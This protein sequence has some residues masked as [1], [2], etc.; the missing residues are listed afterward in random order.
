VF[1]PTQIDKVLNLV[2][3]CLGRGDEAM[4]NDF[5]WPRA[6]AA[7][8]LVLATLAVSACG[9]RLTADQRV[10]QARTQLAEGDLATAMIHLRNALQEDPMNQGARLLLAEV[11]LQAGDYGSAAKEYR[12]ALDLGAELEPIR[13][14]YA[15][16]LVRS[17]GAEAALAIT[18]PEQAGEGIE[19]QYWRALALMRLGRHEE[20]EPLL[21]R[22][23]ENPSMHARGQVALAR[24]VLSQERPLEALS[25]LEPV[26]EAA[27]G[28]SDYWEVKAFASLQTGQ[29]D[30][31][32]E[33][34]EQ[35]ARTVT[36]ALGNQRF[37]FRGGRVEALLA[38]GKLAEARELAERLRQAADRNPMANYLMARIELQSGNPE[39]AL[40][41][42]QAVL[43][44]DPDSSA[45][46]MVVGAAYQALRQATLAER[47]LARA[48]ALDPGN[49]SAR[50]M[51]AQTRLGLAEPE[52]ALEALGPMA[53]QPGDPQAVALAGLASARAGDLGAAIDLFKRQLEANPQDDETRTLLA[54]SLISAGRV[55][56]AMAELG[57][58]KTTD[59]GARQR[60]ELIAVAAHLQAG[61][62]GKARA[63][64]G[65]LA[66]ASPEDATLRS[67]LGALFLSRNLQDEA[68][69]WFE[70]ALRVDADHVASHYNLGIIAAPAGRLEEARGHFLA[71]LASNP[72]NGAALAA[73]AQIEWFTGRREDAV[74][75]LQ[76]ARAADARDVSARILLA[77]YLVGLN[78][79]AD[80]LVVAREA[81]AAMPDSA[82]AHNTLGSV[83]LVAGHAREALVSFNRAHQLEPGSAGYLVNKARAEASLGQNQEARQ[84]LVNA[85]ALEPENATALVALVD[86]ERRLGRGEAAMQAFRRLERAVPGG[87]PRIELTRGQLLLD[88][89]DA[90]A[91][92]QAYQ[93]ALDGG[94]G[95]QAVI[96]I[97]QARLRGSPG[98]PAEPL[99]TWLR[100]QP[101]DTTVRR[102]LADHYLRSE[103]YAAALLE[104]ELI[105]GT[106][107]DNPAV[108]NNLAWLYQ[109]LDDGRALETAQ[110]AYR[111]APNDPNVA[112]TLGWI[113]YNQGDTARA[114]ELIS[115]AAAAAPRAGEIQYHHAVLLAETGDKEGA[116]RAARTV[117]AEAGAVNYHQRAQ[118]LLERLESGKE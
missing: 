66:E 55:E 87:H 111:L 109:Q 61:E 18:D 107:P 11:A 115:K 23:I 78:R 70:E 56:E 106:T 112:D 52:R 57:R 22:V 67:T 35:A 63:A 19:L 33:A 108:L 17:G 46:H 30:Q 92:E 5:R 65:A 38:A 101:A 14:A 80:A 42:G 41:H 50:R 62:T 86:M 93:A 79:H 48:V 3:K 97:Y 4:L 53:T 74:A 73:L 40:A 31:A 27:A 21:A 10:D 94:V 58:I 64:A 54:V 51:L 100:A 85:L 13:L 7:V 72:R 77:G 95:S 90:E 9:S 75:H 32:A 43:A 44:A 6:C 103:E 91:A 60:A 26:A 28:D 110:R 8:L 114:L 82:L 118:R 36:D 96:G 99:R 88:E 29:Y 15:E 39:Q 105:A 49:S 84:T 98:E 34:F 37:R 25:M 76:A 20:A 59:A 89:G 102:V 68:V 83:Q 113:L 81:T 1:E 117:L 71:I 116:R 104:Y 16:A 45:G 24:L 2:G 47:H 69:V 12:S